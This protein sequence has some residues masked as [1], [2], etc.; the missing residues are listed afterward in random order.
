MSVAQRVGA[1]F[2][3]GSSG[4]SNLLDGHQRLS[5]GSQVR[6]PKIGFA[7][8]IYHHINRAD[9]AKFL[10]NGQG[11][12]VE[13]LVSVIKRD[14]DGSLRKSFLK[15]GAQPYTGKTKSLEN[16][17]VVAKQFGPNEMVGHGRSRLWDRDFVIHENRYGGVGLGTA[18]ALPVMA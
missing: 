7:D 2:D 12:M 4:R 9:H 6:V 3:S 13:I 1:H 15:Q 17:E 11:V 18:H 5:F 14:S 10:K 8:S 16:S